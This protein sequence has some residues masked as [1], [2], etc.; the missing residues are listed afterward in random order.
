MVLLGDRGQATG[1]LFGGPHPNP[2]SGVGLFPDEDYF[3]QSNAP[4]STFAAATV[5]LAGRGGDECR[6]VIPSV[7]PLRSFEGLIMGRSIQGRGS[8]EPPSGGSQI[9]R[10][11]PSLQECRDPLLFHHTGVDCGILGFFGRP[12]WYSDPAADRNI[13]IQPEGVERTKGWCNAGA[14][15]IAPLAKTPLP[16]ALFGHVAMFLGAEDVVALASVCKSLR[17]I[18]FHRD[19]WKSLC[20]SAGV[21]SYHRVAASPRHQP[22]T[23]VTGKRLRCTKP[24]NAAQPDLNA[25]TRKISRRRDTISD[26]CFRLDSSIR[27]SLQ[28]WPSCAGLLREDAHSESSSSDLGR[29]CGVDRPDTAPPCNRAARCRRRQSES[30]IYPLP[31]ADKPWEAGLHCRGLQVLSECTRESRLDAHI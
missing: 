2:Q 31:A 1:Q 9:S 4:G 14:W 25:H 13:F 26:S 27:N 30:E 6:A 3:E 29:R 10:Q 5:E 17:W 24:S 19:T 20:F 22:G 18:A 11:P 12:M 8:T 28:D 7:R 21:V 16:A 23:R 15:A